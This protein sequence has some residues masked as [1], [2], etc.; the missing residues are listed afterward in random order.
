M[1]LRPDDIHSLTDFKRR[2]NDHIKKLARSGRPRVLTI[3]GRARL[4][5]QDAAAYQ[6][7]LDAVDEAEAIAGIQR[8]LDA[9][10]EG[11]VM[12]L[13]EAIESLKIRSRL[14]RSA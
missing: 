9:V 1:S 7:L 13:R 12:P 10:K 5:V 2:T 14:R 6:K 8:G 11:R 3:N 4:V